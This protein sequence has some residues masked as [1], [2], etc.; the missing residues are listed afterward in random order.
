MQETAFISQTDVV[1]FLYRHREKLG[2]RIAGLHTQKISTLLPNLCK[3]ELITVNE[4]DLPI[5]AFRK[6]GVRE[7]TAAPVLDS[8]Q[9]VEVYI[10]CGVWL[11][12]FSR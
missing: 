10:S 2:G 3:T 7:V 5:S 1:S 6:L 9:V 11:Y 4:A 12:S 8:Q